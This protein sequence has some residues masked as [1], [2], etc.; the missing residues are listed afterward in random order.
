MH[1]ADIAFLHEIEDVLHPAT[2]E[3]NGNF[4]H[5]AQVG[6]NETESGFFVSR[7]SEFDSQ[8]VL[9][10]GFEEGK[11]AYFPD[12][13]LKAVSCGREAAVRRSW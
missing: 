8:L 12:I 13:E 2:L 5:K 9:F 10:L 1:K 3:I 6:G 7:I 11:V 4:D